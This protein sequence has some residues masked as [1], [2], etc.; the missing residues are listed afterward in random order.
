MGGG[1]VEVK[2]ILQK[3]LRSKFING[4]VLVEGQEEVVKK[5]IS[6]IS[7]VPSEGRDEDP[8][9]CMENDLL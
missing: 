6:S 4:A 8:R 3:F 7:N 1:V 2:K 9:D 5:K